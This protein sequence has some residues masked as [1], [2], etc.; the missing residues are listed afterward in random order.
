MIPIDLK[1][2]T[3]IV[4]GA[5]R[6]IGRGIALRLAEAGAAVAVNYS[7]HRDKAEEVVRAV[8]AKGGRAIAVGADVADEAQVQA[9]VERTESELG[10][11]DIMVANAGYTTVAATA[12]LDLATWQRLIDVNLTGAFLS[13]RAIVPGML[14]RGGGRVIFIS[15]TGAITGGGGGPHYA[16]SKAGLTGLVRAMSR[17]LAAKGILVNAVAPTA[18]ESDFLLDRYPDPADRKRLADSVPVGRLGKPEDIGN[19]VA[20]LASE[21]ATFIS[22]QVLIADGGRTFK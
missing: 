22:G 2:K 16:A 8:R 17:E 12:E 11:V 6:G 14:A 5:S 21:L 18:I 19:V 20:F 15:S 10:P 7:E 9:M 3:A 4:T 1:G 13:A